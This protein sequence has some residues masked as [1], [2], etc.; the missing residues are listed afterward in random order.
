MVNLISL[1]APISYIAV[2]L[3]SLIAFSSLYRKRKNAKAASLEPWFPPHTARDV[4]LSLLHQDEESSVPDTLLKAA[5]MLRAKEDIRRLMILRSSKG[6][7]QALLQKGCVGDDLWTRFS[8]A[9]SEMEEELRDVVTEANA[10]KEGWGQLIFP[11]ANEMVNHDRIKERA[12]KVA[13]EAE[14]ESKWWNEKRE[15][16]S[17]ELLG[18]EGATASG[19]KADDSDAAVEKVKNKSKRTAKK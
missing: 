7:L 18:E 8:R 12:E 10:Y 16:A 15:R 19:G 14:A 9:E 11:T 5:L 1:I 4:Y 13:V 3:G 6:S 17:R 2:L